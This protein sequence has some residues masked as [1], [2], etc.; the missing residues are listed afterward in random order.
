MFISIDK[1]KVYLIKF[2]SSFTLFYSPIIFLYYKSFGINISQIGIIF[3]ITS[4]TTIIFEVP[5]GLFADKKSLKLSVFI[6]YFVTI[7]G[8]LVMIFSSNF[9]QFSIAAM[10]VAIGDAGVSGASTIILM[11]LLENEDEVFDIGFLTKGISN[12]IGGLLIGVIYN[13]NKKLPLW[14]SFLVIILNLLL[15][16]SI[17]Y[18]NKNSESKIDNNK[19]N[20]KVSLIEAIKNNLFILVILFFSYISVPQIMIYFPEYLSFNNFNPEFIG[21][22]YMIANF[23][24]IIGTKINQKYLKKFDIMLRLK[25]SFLCLVIIS[26]F[27]WKVNNSIIFMIFYLIY[28]IITGG[29]FSLFSVYINNNTNEKY[30]ATL[31]SISSAITEF[32]FVISDPLITYL[33]SNSSIKISYMFAF[34]VLIFCY[35]V[36][37]FRKK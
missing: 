15:Y 27:M 28:R 22:M 5:F 6:G 20:E 21:I 26:F 8:M 25:Y 30:K 29:F 31:F 7:L 36:V 34:F 23:F 3:A 32:A 16:L 2:F 9:W 1:L 19:N 14:I 4:I 12:I 11:S 24:S 17:K 10:L 33:I 35:I 37:I 18:D 13:F